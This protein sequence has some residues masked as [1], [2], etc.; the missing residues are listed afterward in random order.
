MRLIELHILQSFPVSCLNRDEVGQPKSAVFGGVKRARLSS[1]T[2]RRAT[3]LD[4][5][6]QLP[7]FYTGKRT[8]YLPHL[9]SE[10]VPALKENESLLTGV[11]KELASF[12][13][14]KV[15]KEPKRFTTLVFSSDSE[16]TRL[17]KRVAEAL[18]GLTD[19]E[20][21][22]ISVQ[23]KSDEATNENEPKDEGKKPPKKGPAASAKRK[24]ED[25]FR[26][27]FG[28]HDAA[29]I[30]IFGRMVADSPNLTVESAAMFSHALSTHE[31]AGDYDFFAAVDE[32]KPEGEA[33]G[34]AITDT[35]QFT[36]AVYYRYVGL[37]LDLLADKRHLDFER[38]SPEDRK[39]VV[40]S[41]IRSV[42][43]AVPGTY[44]DAGR[45]NGMNAHTEVGYALGFL[46]DKAQPIQLVNAFEDPVRRN[47]GL[48][49]PSVRRLLLQLQRVKDTYGDWFKADP[50]LAT[51]VFRS[52]P[53]KE[54]TGDGEKLANV[55]NQQSLPV[56]CERLANAA[57]PNPA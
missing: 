51:G 25:A 31:A 56:F 19:E 16:K 17:W 45:R 44:E 27:S 43:V 22:A 9:L 13:N 1:Q 50:E 23:E 5:S 21:K 14:N 11:A 39:K 54:E 46:R 48:L 38:M 33:I 32:Q 57:V 18:V 20:K 10:N 55:P 24:L 6:K 4:A 3:R 30:A 35:L 15:D 28:Q 42:L 29:D 36:S 53:D 8:R 12:L 41:F 34:A 7:T 52:K 2:L 26:A 49:A 47:G 40:E 37:N